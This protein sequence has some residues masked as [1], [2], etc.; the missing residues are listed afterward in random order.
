MQNEESYDYVVV[1]A[2]SAGCVVAAR[3]LKRTDARILLLEAGGTDDADAVHRTDILS[4][5]SL[6]GPQGTVWGYETVPQPGLGGRTISVPQGRMLGGGS[7]VNAMMWVRGNRRD[8]DGWRDLGNEGWGYEDVLPY[9][10]R[11][12]SYE[13]SVS[14]YR[15][16]GG[17]L[18][19]VPYARPAEVSRA[20][21]AAAGEL[22]FDGPGDYNG[23]RQENTAFFYQSTR[24]KDNRRAST[25]VAYLQ[26]VLG[27]PRL[28]V[29]TGA[30]A[31]RLV[32]RGGRAAGVE[33]LRDGEP[34]TATARAE[35][36]LSAGALA[37]PRLLMLSGIGPDAELRGHGIDPVVDLPGVGRNLQDHLLFG[38]AYESPRELPVP[39][40]LS[41]AGLFTTARPSGEDAAPDLQYF[42]G[43][44]QFV[45]ERYKTDAPGFTFAPILARPRSRGTVTLASADVLAPPV[46][47][48]HYLEAEEDLEVL[49][50]G[51]TLARELARTRALT[52][53][54]GRELA[55][56]ADVTSPAG[57]ARYVRESAST[58]WHPVGTCRMG[59]DGGSVV[60]ARLRVHG[61][62][63]LRIADAS[64]MPAITT[65]NT[66]AAVVMIG[67]K[68]ADL[69][70]ADA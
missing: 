53:F 23:E 1:G 22:G 33:Y 56:G 39:E 26:P 6:W 19:V 28:T 25:A 5:V 51:I 49:V 55:P 46:V 67:E 27:H 44:V 64:V 16:V 8:F 40:L 50:R 62:D 70:G 42:F 47:D 20:F 29:V 21:V 7:S 60:D 2:G 4:M 65:G 18:S 43:P 68:A 36:V 3:L 37:T 13:E 12:E 66:N 41:E 54:R 17:P 9:F 48:P 35:V 63:G 69:I 57:L 31:T 59:A 30:T 11:S 61:V 34:H 52:P 10:R 14:R 15:G 38:V 58:V 24:T 45:D 32:L